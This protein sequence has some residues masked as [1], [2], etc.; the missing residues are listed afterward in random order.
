MMNIFDFNFL[1]SCTHQNIGEE[2][3]FLNILDDYGFYGYF[4]KM[5]L[6]IYSYFVYC[7]GLLIPFVGPY[8]A[9]IIDSL[10][11]E[12]HKVSGL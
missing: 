7:Y 6:W 8:F 4:W 1:M 2:F 11:R 3:P 9:K 12:F 10:F 5:L